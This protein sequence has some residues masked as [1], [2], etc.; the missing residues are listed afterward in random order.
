M[1][2]RPAK[3][4][5]IV[6]A[7]KCTGER[8][9]FEMPLKEE[10]EVDCQVRDNGV[11]DIATDFEPLCVQWSDQLG[12]HNGL[13]STVH[14]YAAAEF[15]GMG[16]SPEIRLLIGGGIGLYPEI[17]QHRPQHDIHFGDREFGAYAP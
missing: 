16:D 7:L 5:R 8:P 11:A 1:A 9:R 10:D 4:G 13:L 15:R 14:Y 6:S 2:I 17:L 12:R 3:I